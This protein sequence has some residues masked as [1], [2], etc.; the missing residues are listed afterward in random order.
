MYHSRIHK[1][2]TF[3]TRKQI[4]FGINDQ[5]ETLKKDTKVSKI[6]IIFE[7]FW[8]SGVYTKRIRCTIKVF[9]YI[10]NVS[11]VPCVHVSVYGYKSRDFDDIFSIKKLC[12]HKNLCTNWTTLGHTWYLDYWNCGFILYDILA[13][14]A[15]F[16][17]C[18]TISIKYGDLDV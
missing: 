2:D 10:L 7:T 16:S 8:N 3:W 14:L 13:P 5:P 1:M 4:L 17:F 6:R 11:D 15:G 18:S 9:L 12:G